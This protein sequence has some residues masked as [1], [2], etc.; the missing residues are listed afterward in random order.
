MKTTYVRESAM[1]NAPVNTPCRDQV[2]RAEVR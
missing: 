2:R 1:V